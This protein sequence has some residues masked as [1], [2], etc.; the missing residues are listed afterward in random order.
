MNHLTLQLHNRHGSMFVR[1]ELDKREA[2]VSLHTDFGE[3][4]DRLEKR[5]EVRLGTIG[6][7]IANIDSGVIRRGL[8][9]DRFVRQRPTLE[10]IGA[11]ALPAPPG[12][13]EATAPAAA[14]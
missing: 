4:A 7:K 10:L 5:D 6:H 11:G 8:L 14:P 12:R 9:D 13:G 1:V 2:T 3:V